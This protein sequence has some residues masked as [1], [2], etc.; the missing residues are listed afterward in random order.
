MNTKQNYRRFLIIAFIAFMLMACG[1]MNAQNNYLGEIKMFA[2]NFAPNGWALCD[3]S[4]LSI[5]NNQA[6]FALLGT[7]YGGDGQTTFALPD[8]RG[9]VPID[10]GQGAGL[11]YRNVGDM[12]G[13]ETHT[14][15][16]SEIPTHSHSIAADSSVG[17]SDRPANGLPARNAAGVPQYGTGQNTTLKSNTIGTTGGSNPHNN[18]QPYTTVN[19]IIALQGI[20]PSRN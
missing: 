17:T 16:I 12:G 4:L 9:R 19:F 10:A 3:G 15:I 2:G 11:T 20:F 5:N 13:E 18:M 6:L 1:E 7:M 14:L 8:L